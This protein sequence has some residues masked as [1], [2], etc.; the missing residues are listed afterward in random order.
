MFKAVCLHVHRLIALYANVVINK[1]TF[2][3]GKPMHF[4]MLIRALK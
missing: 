4:S 1:K 3:Q 2:A